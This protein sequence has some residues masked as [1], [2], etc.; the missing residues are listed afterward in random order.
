V[1]DVDP[2]TGD[3]LERIGQ[4]MKELDKAGLFNQRPATVSTPRRR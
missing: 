3:L 1:T 2:V 4:D